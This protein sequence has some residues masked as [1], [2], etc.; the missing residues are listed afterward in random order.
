M[1]TI[2]ILTR[3]NSASI[4]HLIHGLSWASDI[5][6]IDDNSSDATVDLAQKAG[7]RSIV[8]ELKNDYSSARTLAMDEAKYN[9]VLFLDAD[10]T[11]DSDAVASIKK[12]NLHT[13]KDAG[14]RIS[15]VDYFWNQRVSH[16]EVKSAYQTGIIRLINRTQGEWVGK[17]HERFIPTGTIG[18]LPGLIEHRSHKSISDFIERVNYFSDIRAQELVN[19]SRI[20]TMF[21][22]VLLPPGKFI[23]TYFVCLGF[24]DG[25]AGFVYS[26]MMSFHSFLVRAKILSRENQSL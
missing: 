17:V 5:L 11:L 3:N 21:E 26:F 23:Y 13:A 7:A 20:R 9:W 24:M 19:Q 4:E 10:E 15:R 12:L 8:H 2:A 18:V 25:A 6:V 14:F 22:M 1:L 16:G